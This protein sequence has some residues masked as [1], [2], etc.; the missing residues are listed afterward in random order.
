M[1]MKPLAGP[2]AADPAGLPR[3]AAALGGDQSIIIVDMPSMKDIINALAE[4]IPAAPGR[5]EPSEEAL[6]TS[7]TPA[8]GSETN[9]PVAVEEAT[10]P[11][12][13]DVVGR[14]LPLLFI[15]AYDGVGYHSGRTL[16]LENM[17]AQ[18]EAQ[19]GPMGVDSGWLTAAQQ[20]MG[21]ELGGWTLR[22]L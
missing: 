10:A 14:T 8:E 6:T 1:L 13:Q 9:P 11:R 17:F 15:R 7:N 2:P 20:A 21:G 5:V 19:G 4:E 16:A 12:P 22:V 18:Y 3:Y